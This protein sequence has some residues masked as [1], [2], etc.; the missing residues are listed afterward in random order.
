MQKEMKL[1]KKTFTLAFF[2]TVAVLAVL[3]PYVEGRGG[4]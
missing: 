4:G 2:A 3:R 1:K